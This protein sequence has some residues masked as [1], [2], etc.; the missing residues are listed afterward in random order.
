MFLQNVDKFPRHYMES[1]STIQKLLKKYVGLK[2][3]YED[4]HESIMWAKC[5]VTSC[6]N[7]C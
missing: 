3:R 5:R 4:M 6:K 2:N 1:H 7:K